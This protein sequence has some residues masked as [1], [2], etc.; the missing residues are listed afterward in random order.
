MTTDSSR[1]ARWSAIET[2]SRAR[3]SDRLRSL[4]FEQDDLL[5]RKITTLRL[6][7]SSSSHT[8][9]NTAIRMAS[10]ESLHSFCSM[11]SSISSMSSMGSIGNRMHAT[12]R[13]SPSTS[14]FR[15]HNKKDSMNSLLS[16]NSRWKSTPQKK[17][18]STSNA[19]MQHLRSNELGPNVGGNDSGRWMA[20]VSSDNAMDRP[21]SAIRR[22]ASLSA[23]RPKSTWRRC[24]GMATRPTSWNMIDC[25]QHHIKAHSVRAKQRFRPTQFSILQQSARF[26]L[27]IVIQYTSITVH[28]FEV[29][30]SF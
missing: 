7:T 8:M 12:P 30:I 13:K 26:V 4:L 16:L 27:I 24:S 21:I 28:N 9:P 1:N 22:K 18:N 2:T 5:S 14:K 17:R 23:I 20:T 19:S 25:T 11:S 3:S 29:W 10:M 15:Y 6:D